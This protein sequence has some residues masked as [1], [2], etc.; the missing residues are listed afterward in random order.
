MLTR[1]EAAKLPKEMDVP[2]YHLHSLNGCLEGFW[3][4]RVDKNYR[5]IFRMERENVY[6]VD[7]IDYH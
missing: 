1:L 5:I 6:D 4:V 2:G 3:S 7:Y